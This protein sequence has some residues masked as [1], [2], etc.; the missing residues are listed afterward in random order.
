M[1]A[2]S[3]ALATSAVLVGLC[4]W[5][6][7]LSAQ[8]LTKGGDPLLTVLAIE[9][10]VPVGGKKS[11][12]P[13][14]AVGDKVRLE[15]QRDGMAEVV[16]EE[17]EATAQ[18]ERRFRL[19]RT[20]LATAPGK[21]HLD[22]PDWLPAPA[23]AATASRD[24]VAYADGPWIMLLTP[25]A[26]PIRVAKG[27]APALSRDAAFLAYSPEPGGGVTVV[28]RTGQ[29]KPRKFATQNAFVRSM[30]FNPDGRRL[31]WLVDGRIET[32]DLAATNPS[33]VVIHTGLPS[34]CSLQGSTRD[35]TALV[36]QDLTN[37]TWIGLD[38]TRIR[39]EPIGTFTDDP[40]GSSA[41]TYLPSPTDDAL[42]LVARDVVGSA[43]FARWGNGP[44]T[45]LYLYDAKS[46][47]NYRLTPRSLT[48]AFP[49]WTPDGKRI[50][51]AG[52]P[53]TP[54]NG[55]QWIYRMNA[56]GTGLTQLGKGWMP[57]VGTRPE[58]R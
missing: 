11:K 52:L 38:G 23:G 26:K 48:A 35:G 29:T 31:F 10:A 20:A 36:V 30:H 40:W 27:A 53:E 18:T 51:F 28:D 3:I 42:M 56:D 2:K 9:Q 7:R 8:I 43:A 54:A 47:T 57:S 37:V 39:Q 1:T 49:A 5:P 50:Y 45:A 55:P 41:D 34:D 4:L 21:T 25:G 33:P 16:I 22:T 24:V 13:P 14:L 32:V 46:G 15:A 6:G 17:P 19:P 58:G 44:G 12:T